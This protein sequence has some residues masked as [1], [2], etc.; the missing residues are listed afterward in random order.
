MSSDDKNKGSSEVQKWEGH[1]SSYEKEFKAWESRVDKILKRYRDDKRTTRTEQASKFNILWSNVQTLTAATFS[2]MPKPDVSRR[3]RD[4]DAVGRV[5][6]LILERALD[7]EVQHYTDYGAT[8]RAC[9]C[10]R[11]LGGRGTAWARYEPHMR[12]PQAPSGDQITEDVDKPSEELDYECAPVDYVHWKDFGHVVARTWEEVPAVWRRVYLTRASCVERFGEKIGSKVPLDANPEDL[13]RAKVEGGDTELSRACIY[14]IWDKT[15]KEAIWLSR[16]LKEVLDKKPDPLGLEEFFPCPK[17]LFATLTNDS[18]IP[19]PDFTLYQDQ[20]NELDTLADRI[21]GLVKSL[22]VMGGYDASIPELARLFTEGGNTDLVPIKNW[23]A[24]AEKNGLQGSLSLVDLQPIAKA[25]AEAYKAF[26]QIKEQIYEITGIS[27]IIRGQ[28]DASETATAQQIKGQYASLRLKQYQEEVARFA[29]EL[30]QLKAQIMCKKFAPQTLQQISAV[31]QLSQFDQQEVGNAMALL[32]GQARVADPTA[33]D[34]PNPMR[35][36]RIEVAT[37]S[38]V[39]LDEQAEKQSRVEF[40]TATG[41]F[42]EKMAQVLVQTPP[43][44]RGVIVGLLME[45][46]KFGVTGFKVGKTIEGAFDSAADQLKQ[47][48]MQPP[49]PP[50]PDPKLQAAKVKANA[51]MQRTQADV[52]TL[53]MR[54][55]AETMRAQADVMTANAEVQKA[56]LQAMTPQ[57]PQAPQ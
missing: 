50:Q 32:V 14:E 16:S 25:L 34:G 35:S 2:K 55:Q 36:F 33:E 47:L 51:D 27:D 31:D 40:L 7:F 42:I 45:M 39:Y 56:H 29:T 46:L 43:E 53:P 57:F 18:L 12:D 52:I 23:Q 11:F 1:I 9:V 41:T 20:A 28:T 48:A 6:S 21:D 24:F 37:D 10:D 17:P 44:A 5:A 26:Q 15:N 49:P 38:L 30:L 3:F 4:Q 54:T 19:V 13:K 8:L 22:K